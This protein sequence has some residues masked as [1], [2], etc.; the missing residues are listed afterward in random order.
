MTALSDWGIVSDAEL[1]A[2]AAA[3]D[4]AAFAAIYDR[5]ADRLHDFCVVRVRD[6]D[7]AADCVQDVFCIAATRLGQL[8]D[9][10]KLRPWLYAIAGN[11]ALRRIRQR[12]REQPSGVMAADDDLPEMASAD[13]GPDTLAARSELAELIAEAAGGLSERDRVVLELSY[14]H[15]LDGPELARALGVSTSN[16]NNLVGRLRQ[17]IERSLGALLVAR[18]ARTNPR[19][20]PQLGEILAGWDGK[21]S[22]L[23]RKRIARHIE[24]CPTCDEQRRRLVSPTALLG[25][26]PVFIPAPYW[27]RNQTLGQIHLTAATAGA[28]TA[29]TG[30]PGSASASTNPDTEQPLA[31]GEPGPDDQPPD[32]TGAG[33]TGR[34]IR[35]AALFA[36]TLFISLGLTLAWLH[37]LHTTGSN[38]SDSITNS[39]PKPTTSAAPHTTQ[40]TPNNASPPP[41]PARTT[42]APA[43]TAPPDTPTPS[44]TPTPTA[45]PPATPNTAGPTRPS[46]G[47]PARTGAPPVNVPP[48]L[49]PVNVPPVLPPVISIPVLPPLIPQPPHGCHELW[50]A[51]P[52]PPPPPHCP[53][54]CH[55]PPPPQPPPTGGRGSTR[56]SQ[57]AQ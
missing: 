9:P 3:G 26:T 7:T 29:G 4:R 30:E 34:T 47:G 48:V 42:T 35:L 32:D 28:S 57:V 41:P 51:T 53:P 45:Q 21:F 38:P 2:A 24:S 37:Q 31:P 44:Q 12:R 54:W 6:R 40:A 55:P 46:S 25:A 43:T 15:G 19:G 5:Y 39:T 17:T 11:E 10:D 23:M 1:A 22:V 52:P 13:A 36:S 20:C 18:S 27:L 33:R 16:A 8:R 50:C 56:S 49:P 14:R